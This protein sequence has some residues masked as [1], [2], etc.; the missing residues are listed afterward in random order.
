MNPGLLSL[1]DVIMEAFRRNY[2]LT[3]EG[4]E[5]MF[6]KWIEGFQSFRPAQPTNF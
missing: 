4:A 1:K 5:E 6:T 2:K 3:E